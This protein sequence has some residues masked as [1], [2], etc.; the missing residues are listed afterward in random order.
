[1][2]NIWI[3]GL[4][5]NL[6]TGYFFEHSESFPPKVYTVEIKGMEF[7]PAQIK[8]K[9]GDTIV[10]INKDIVVH[11]VTEEKRKAWTSSLIPIGKSWKMVVKE[12]SLY[13]CTL[14]PVMKGQIQVQ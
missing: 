2:L 4:C 6:I 9:K 14:H 3:L 8:V 5:L 13:Y 11:T 7:L 1:M 12:S 10:W